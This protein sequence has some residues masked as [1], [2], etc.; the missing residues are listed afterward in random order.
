MIK[1][2]RRVLTGMLSGV[3][4][5]SAFAQEP[6]AKPAEVVPNVTPPVALPTAAVEDAFKAPAD[7]AAAPADAVKSDSGLASKVLKA[8]TGT[9]KPRAIDATTVNYTGWTVSDGKMFDSSAK[10]REP[11]TFVLEGV[12]KGWTEG[13]QLMV[14]GEKR[15][16]WIPAKLAYEGNPRGPQGDLVFDV[17]LVKIITRP[18]APAD[19]AAAPADGEK[20]PSGLV[21]KVLKAGEGKEKPGPQDITKLSFTGWKPDGEFIVDTAMNG[22]GPGEVKLDQ[23]PVKGLSEG[24]QQMVAGEKRRL[25]IPASLGFGELPAEGTPPVPNGPPMGPLVFDVELVS[26]EDYVDPFPAPADVATAP[27]DSTKSESGLASRVLKASESTEKPKADD[28]VTFAFTGWKANGEFI[29][30]SEQQGR[31]MNVKLSD[32]PI[33][34]WTEGIQLMAKGEKRRFWLPAAL[35]FKGSPQEDALV[36]DVELLDFKTPPP[37]PTAPVD[38]AAAPADAEKAASGLASKVLIKGEGLKKPGAT[39]QVTVHYTGWTTDGKMFDSSVA[40]GEP[41]SF[42]LNQVIKG[43]TEGLQLMVEGESRRFW[44]P[45]E[46]AY[47]GQP[48]KPAGMLVFDVQLIKIDQ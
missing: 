43:W 6:A 5:L 23:F 4:G 26:F 25:W 32:A 33:L 9:Q 21:S 1:T 19:L 37:A 48:G 40:R 36:F 35:G 17:E 46:L 44:I 31:P 7:L 42:G 15:R 47:Q 2:K 34:G 22:Q 20:L 24:V 28:M 29:G 3:V 41:S 11:T 14:E 38:V 13:L 30:G 27:A 18:E 39:S 45:V 10:R 16:F 8:G 12:I